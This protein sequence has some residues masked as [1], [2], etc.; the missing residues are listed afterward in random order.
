MADSSRPRPAL[1]RLA[2]LGYPATQ[3]HFV[4]VRIP[5]HRA[6]LP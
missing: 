1:P 6:L 2:T 3:G 4:T 5:A